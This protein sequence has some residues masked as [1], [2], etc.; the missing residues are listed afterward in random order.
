MFC[1]LRLRSADH[2][3]M[4]QELEREH[5]PEA[6]LVQSATEALS[7]HDWADAATLTPVRDAAQHLT[8]A[9]WEH[10]GIEEAQAFPAATRHLLPEDWSAVAQAFTAHVDP[11][12]DVDVG[13]P[14]SVALARISASRLAAPSARP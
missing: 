5:A 13:R 8:G 2:E 12:R 11:L 9:L 6:A 7:R 3:A 4:L 10:M 14:L 1:L